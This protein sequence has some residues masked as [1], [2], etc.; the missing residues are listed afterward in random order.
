LGVP[1]DRLRSAAG[2]VKVLKLIAD[3]LLGGQP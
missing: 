3:D 2:H 1:E